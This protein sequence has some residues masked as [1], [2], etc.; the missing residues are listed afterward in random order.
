MLFL[1][2]GEMGKW[3]TLGDFLKSSAPSE[4]WGIWIDEY[5]YASLND[6]DTF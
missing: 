4:V 5:R 2:E 3:A 6:G 1:P